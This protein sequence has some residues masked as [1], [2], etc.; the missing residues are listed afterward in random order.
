MSR[1]SSRRRGQYFPVFALLIG[2]LFTFTVMVYNLFGYQTAAGVALDA[3]I[4]AAT[5]GAAQQTDP[6]A[7]ALGRWYIT[8]DLTGVSGTTVARD[9]LLV[10]ISGDTVAYAAGAPTGSLRGMFSGDVTTL[11]GYLADTAGTSELASYGADVEIVNPALAVGQVSDRWLNGVQSTSAGILC[12]AEYP[13]EVAS[14]LLGGKCFERAAVV[15]RIRLPVRQ[16]GSAIGDIVRIGYLGVG[17][18]V[19]H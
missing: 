14:S 10:G 17:T 15:I 7:L 9:L 6:E 19:Q 13:Q 18:D 5:Y 3:S 4:R 2:A 11:R 12:T 16:L 8:G 1:S